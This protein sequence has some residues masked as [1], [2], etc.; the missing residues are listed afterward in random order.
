VAV[1]DA[2][3]LVYVEVLADEQG[4]TVTGFLWRALAWYRR[5][6]IRVRRLLTEST[7][8]STSVP[9]ASSWSRVWIE[10]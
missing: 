9:T 5:L 2:T 8:T 10:R 6:G 3:R 7:S 4:V 1:D